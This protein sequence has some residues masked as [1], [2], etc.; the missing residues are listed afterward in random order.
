MNAQGKY[1]M[2]M[3][4]DKNYRGSTYDMEQDGV[5]PIDRGTQY[6]QG[7][8][9]FVDGILDIVIT[10]LRGRGLAMGGGD[11]RYYTH[12]ISNHDYHVRPVQGNR[13]KINYSAIL[14]P[15]IP[16][17]YQGEEFNSYNPPQVIYDGGVDFSYLETPSNALFFEDVKAAIRVRRT[18]PDLFE[19]WPMKHINT[20]LCSV[21]IEGWKDPAAATDTSLS[22]YAR[23]I[24]PDHENATTKGQAV[25]VIP[26]HVETVSGVGT[27][28]IPVKDANLQGYASFTVTDLS[29]GRLIAIVPASAPI[30]TVTIPY[31][32]VGMYLVE[33][34]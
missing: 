17:W 20:N 11:Y 31:N 23:F 5:L 28:T 4:E 1:V 15:Y 29:T 7:N 3:A 33:G 2:I 6:S 12:C 18:Y 8:S 22:A 10:S 25:L 19:Y 26:N 27:V 21:E 16:L 9:F 24:S 13:L 30:F 32:Y 14:A 34:M